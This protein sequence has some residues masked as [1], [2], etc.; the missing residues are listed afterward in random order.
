[1]INKR[2]IF[3]V[4][5]LALS[6]AFL[7]HKFTGSEETK[8]QFLSLVAGP[9]SVTSLTT[10]ASSSPTPEHKDDSAGIPGALS[11]HLPAQGSTA[12]A[13][14]LFD[15]PDRIEGEWLLYFEDMQDLITFIGKA[16]KAGIKILDRL[17][18]LLAIRLWV[19]NVDILNTLL[20]QGPAPKGLDANYL[21]YTPNIPDTMPAALPD[22]YRAFGRSALSWL[23]INGQNSEWGRG[24]TVAILDTGI[25]PHESIDPSRL[26]HINL[27]TDAFDEEGSHAGHGTAVA[28]IL[29]GAGELV[30]GVAPEVDFLS[31]RVLGSDGYGDSFTLTKAIITAVDLGVDE[32]VMSLGTYGD[33]HLLRQAIDY[34][35]DN[36]VVIVASSGNDGAQQITYPARYDGVIAVGAVDRAGQLLW[37]SN[38]GDELDITAPGYGIYAAWTGDRVAEVSGTSFAVPFVAGAIAK[39]LSDN[40]NGSPAEAVASVLDHANDAGP[41]EA[42]PMYGEG[43]LN[44]KRIEEQYENGIYDIAVADYYLA[45]SQGATTDS[46]LGITFENRGTEPIRSV[47][48]QISL[49][50][51]DEY[52]SFQNI[53]AGESIGIDTSFDIVAMQHGGFVSFSAEATTFGDTDTNPANNYGA[54]SLKIQSEEPSTAATTGSCPYK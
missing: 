44:I 52:H 36:N 39:E 34:A 4:F 8:Q 17:D 10:P 27:L 32:I 31:I 29:G 30:S 12:L 11:K 3:C 7:F 42:D 49:N 33:N 23:G 43:I 21:V 22:G 53:S 19:D 38:Q 47:E 18:D 15:T 28:S 46:L 5:V 26:I 13:S 41:P 40:H 6:L 51:Q 24:I 50:G 1:M 9:P 48:V 45:G 54:F 2:Q 16:Q 14:E 37:F 35:L 25:V 20:E